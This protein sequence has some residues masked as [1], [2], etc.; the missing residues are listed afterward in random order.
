M[1]NVNGVVR[2]TNLKEVSPRLIV[3][4]AYCSE[5]IG[6]D[7]ETTFVKVKLV[8]NALVDF[9]KLGL[10]EKDRFVIEKGVLKAN[11]YTNKDKENIEELVITIF[12]LKEFIEEKKEE[13]K[14]DN[15]SKFKR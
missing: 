14:K 10:K 13:P 6:E 2:T 9:C 3:G 11:R 4:S 15:S 12:E 5:K 7:W 8:G 1:F